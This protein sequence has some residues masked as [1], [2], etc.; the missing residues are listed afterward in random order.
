MASAPRVLVALLLAAAPVPAQ[1]SLHGFAP[2]DH[3]TEFRVDMAALVDTE[4]WDLV[5]RSPARMLLAQFRKQFGFDLADLDRVRLSQSVEP[6][7][8]G[9]PAWRVVRHQVWVLEGGARVGLDGMSAEFLAG[10]PRIER[11]GGLEL[12]SD[13]GSG[14][15]LVAPA[16]GALVLSQKSDFTAMIEGRDPGPGPVRQL[17]TGERK[18]GVPVPD[19]MALTASPHALLLIAAV[20]G[21]GT[22]LDPSSMQPFPEE[23]FVADDLPEGFRLQLVRPKDAPERFRFEILVRFAAGDGAGL[24]TMIEGFEASRLAWAEDPRLKPLA[25]ALA[26]VQTRREGADLVAVLDLGTERE[27]GARLSPLL[28]L[29]LSSLLVEVR[30]VEAVERAVVVEGLEAPEPAVEKRR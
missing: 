5:E 6:A 24:K 2:T 9:A 25:V 13:D 20:P 14:Q 4:L 19:L 29:A 22:S 30:E 11:V 8:D 7:P 17:L 23:W 18:G 10:Y 3:T 28:V 16:P 1:V 26:P 21:A 15:E 12:R 27:L